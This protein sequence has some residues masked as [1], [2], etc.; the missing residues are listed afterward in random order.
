MLLTIAVAIFFSFINLTIGLRIDSY[1]KKQ[2]DRLYNDTSQ[3]D[4]RKLEP[5]FGFDATKIELYIQKYPHT[6][7]HTSSD[8]EFDL[9]NALKKFNRKIAREPRVSELKLLEDSIQN[10]ELPGLAEFIE[11]MQTITSKTRNLVAI[12]SYFIIELKSSIIGSSREKS[13][14]LLLNFVCEEATTNIKHQ[15]LQFIN[16]LSKIEDLRIVENLAKDRFNS[17]QKILTENTGDEL[18]KIYASIQ[19]ECRFRSNKL[20]ATNLQI[21]DTQIKLI[22]DLSSGIYEKFQFEQAKQFK[23]YIRTGRISGKRNK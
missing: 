15:L 5:Y 1:S 14:I 6:Q 13:A 16:I 19:K 22:V 21:I 9:Q 18:P 17:F 8:D 7:P 10:T 20:L 3:I 11:N 2:S 4:V 12:I 23:K